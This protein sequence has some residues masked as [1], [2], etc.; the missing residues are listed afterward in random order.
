MN[1]V[2]SLFLWGGGGRGGGWWNIRRVFY[3][4]RGVFLSLG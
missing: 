2:K 1:N 4:L 3:M